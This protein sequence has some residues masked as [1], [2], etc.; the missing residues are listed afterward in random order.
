MR[1]IRRILCALDL[2]DASVHAAAQA[3]ALAAWCHAR[4]TALHVCE[5]VFAP[6]PGLPPPEQRVPDEELAILRDRVAVYFSSVAA[7]GMPVDVVVDVGQPARGIL[8]CADDTSA[9]VIVMATHGAS[10]FEHLMLG[11][12]A[13]KVLRKARCG[14][15]TVSPRV[16]APSARPFTRILC[17]VDFSDPSLAAFDVAAA[18]ARTASAALTVVHV[19]EWPWHEPPAPAAQDMPPAQAAALAEFRRYVETSATMRLEKLTVGL[20]LEPLP[21]LSI[22]HGKSSV[23]ILRVAERMGAD[24]IVM[25]VH[26]RN[27]IDMAL[28]GSTANHIV[29]QATCPVLTFRQ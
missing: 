29:R 15:L 16:P 2:S 12:V 5:P 19:V 17:P 11:S 23:E 26:G 14:V 1:E 7:A 25:G 3:M 27:A 10:G 6:V 20:A 28:F 13:E 21:V 18:L 4:I 22:V 8:G 24:L 9:D